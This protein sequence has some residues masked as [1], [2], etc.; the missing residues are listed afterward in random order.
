MKTIQNVKVT[1]T[2]G[3]MTI[4][5]DLKD[6]PFNGMLTT[7]VTH[8]FVNPINP[9]H[10]RHI[11]SSNEAVFIRSKNGAI[12][13]PN[14]VLIQIAAS[15]EPLTS[16]PPVIKS[17]KLGFV[18]VNSETPVLYQWQVSDDAFPVAEKPHTPAPPAVWK[19]IDGETKP[20]LNM[21]AVKAGQYVRCLVSNFTGV[22]T[23]KAF[24]AS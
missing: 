9:K 20:E 4:C 5:A 12:A 24:K 19:N 7:R 6:T 10:G 16:F 3:R 22:E 11:Q 21:V 1:V 8:G 13:I 15:A 14:N 2:D 17:E 18:E 23:G